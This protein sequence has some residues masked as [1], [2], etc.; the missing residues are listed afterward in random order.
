[1]PIFT[2]PHDATPVWT[3][4]QM[5]PPSNRGDDEAELQCQ[6]CRKWMHGRDHGP[7]YVLELHEG[8]PQTQYLCPSCAQRQIVQT[9]LHA[10]TPDT[11]W[12]GRAMFYGATLWEGMS[13]DGN[14]VDFL[15]IQWTK[16]PPTA[17]EEV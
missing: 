10:A 3:L 16:T 5:P 1:M 8:A 17:G 12:V 14:A 2:A 15:V 4:S 11:K 7:R 6:S 9:W 13:A